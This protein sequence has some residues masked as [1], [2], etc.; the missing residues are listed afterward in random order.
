MRCRQFGLVFI[1]QIIFVA[2]FYLI[3][4]ITRLE[5]AG[6]IASY[7]PF[8]VYR[9]KIMDPDRQY[10]RLFWSAPHIA[11]PLDGLPY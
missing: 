2:I 4:R 6:K 7:Y 3:S 11:I 9:F 5:I 8:F 10:E 1:N